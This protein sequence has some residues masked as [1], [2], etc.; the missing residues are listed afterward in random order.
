MSIVGY[1]RVSSISQSLDIQIELLTDAGCERIFSEKQSGTTQDKR[2]ELAMALDWVREGDT[3]VVTR[4]DRLARSVVDLIDILTKLESK[5]VMFRCL[6]QPVDTTTPT[7]RLM[8]TMLGAF[9]EFETEIRRERQAE[10]IARAKSAG[11]Y[12]GRKHPSRKNEVT[13]EKIIHL[14]DVE[15]LGASAIAKRFKVNRLTI[16]RRVPDG[17]GANPFKKSAD[18]AAKE[19]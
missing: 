5:G 10:G 16:Y 12:D 11:K 3:L 6:Q 15:K 14:R 7:G 19:D 9:A 8:M 2:D 17:W 4:L 18:V 13:A 1:A